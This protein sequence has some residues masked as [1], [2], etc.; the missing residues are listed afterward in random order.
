MVNNHQTN[1]EYFRKNIMFF[2]EEDEDLKLRNRHFAIAGINSFIRNVSSSRGIMASGMVSQAVSLL[3][4]KPNMFQTGT[5]TELGK[6]VLTKKT[7]EMVEVQF[8]IKRHVDMN[9]KVM[10]HLVIF[11]EVETGILDCLDLPNFNKLHQYF[12]FRYNINEN[13]DVMSKGTVLPA[14]TILAKPPTLE[15]DGSYSLGR[16]VNVALMPLGQNDEDGFLIGDETVKK[17]NFSLFESRVIEV[18]EDEFMID[19][20]GVDY[21]KPFMEI[22]EAVRDDGV[23]FGK[24]GFDAEYGALLCSDKGLKKFNPIFDEMVYGRSGFKGIIKDIKVYKNPNRKR[25]VPIGTNELL[26]KYAESLVNYHKQIINSYESINRDFFNTFGKNMEVSERFNTLLVESYGIVE[27]DRP[28]SKIKKMF[29]LSKL[30]LYR[31]EVEIEYVMTPGMHFKFTDLSANKG[32]GVRVI[33]EKD[34]PINEFGVRAGI[35]MDITS[36]PSRQNDGRLYEHSIKGSMLKVRWLMEQKMTELNIKDIQ[37]ANDKSIKVI[38]KIPMDFV[39][40]LGNEL[41]NTYKKTYDES[42]YITMLDVISDI[43]ENEM[44]VYLP[45]GNDKVGYEILESIRGTEYMP[46][47]SRV[48]FTLDGIETTTEVPILIAPL[49]IMLL[50]KIAGDVLTT[51][52][53]YVNTSGLPVVVSKSDKHSLPYRSSPTRVFGETEG[54]IILAYGGKEMLAELKDMNSSIKTHGLVYKQILE[55]PKPTNIPKLINRNIHPYG[56]DRSLEIL[57]TLF[58]SVGSELKHVK[59]KN[60]IV[61]MSHTDELVE[62]TD[63][64][65]ILDTE[66]IE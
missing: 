1:Y 4:P 8:V 51:A 22:G 32:V 31:L 55:A 58:M 21:Y 24:R 33:P 20:G 11:R 7:E 25:A 42:D 5:E 6:Y 38:F 2:K 65:S 62:V 52:S 26:D 13:I 49:Y 63:I 14:D 39:K 37:T 30:G 9:A 17:F 41:Y 27:S 44:K 46:N 59:D 34:M 18:N 29:K 60:R 12:G 36:T 16:D 50:S 61:D 19:I 28:N 54:R 10:E 47:K 48:T 43:L 15:D 66:E 64:N 56:T 40:L 57:N 53:A 45:A 35:V 23:I 3:H